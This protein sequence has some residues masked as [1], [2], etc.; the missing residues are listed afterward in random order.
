MHILVVNDDGIGAE[1]ISVLERAAYQLSDRVSVVAPARE[2]SAQSHAITVAKPIIVNRIPHE[3]NIVRYSVEGTPTDCV[4]LAVLELCEPIDLVISGINHGANLGWEIFFSG[5]VSAAAE[6]FSFGIPAIAFSLATWQ[7]FDFTASEDVATRIIQAITAQYH[8]QE[9]P[10]LYNVNI[11]P[12]SLEEIKGV[13]MTLQEPNI[14]GDSYLSRQT[15]DGR[16]YY[17]ATWGSRQEARDQ[18][19]GDDWDAVAIRNNYVSVTRLKY[20][21]SSILPN[22]YMVDA[23]SKVQFD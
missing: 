18:L 20:E 23:L 21:I 9:E 12:I 7:G 1:G 22:D 13:K 19:E 5:T 3:R 4:R 8:G 10:Y 15:P 11:P 2:H 6:A 16:T 17:W 14:K